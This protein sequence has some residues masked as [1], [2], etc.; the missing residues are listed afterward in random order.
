[1]NKKG[2]LIVILVVAMLIPTAAAEAYYA[3]V[4]GELRESSTNALWIHGASIDVFNCN[5]L[6]SI[7][8]GTVPF[9]SSTFDINI[10][11]VAIDTPLCIEVTFAAGPNGTPGNAAKGP[12]ADRNANSGT[13]NTG[14]YF[15][16]T[17]PNAITLR[18]LSA[19]SAATPWP[20]IL[21]AVIVA[22]AM[23][24]LG[25]MLRRQASEA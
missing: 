17:G 5:T 23:L 24:A 1:M 3:N 22:A 7:N 12:Y 9:G 18:D 8:T 14:V 10:S 4:T 13:L 25:L 16:G 11:G 6:V 15:T 19:E 20:L 2:V 21:A